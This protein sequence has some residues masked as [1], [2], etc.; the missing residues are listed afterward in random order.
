MK[1]HLIGIGGTG[2][3]AMAGL[4]SQAGHEVR[5]SDGPLY[6]PMS[7]LLEKLKIVRYEGFSETNLDWG[8]EIVVVGNICR[9]D[10][11]EAAAAAR[12]G[13]RSVSFP[14]LL[15][16]L[17]LDERRVV[18]VAGTH[19]KTTTTSMMAHLLTQAGRDPGFLVGGIPRDLDGSFAVGRPPFFVV[20]GDEYDCAYF[21]KRPKFVHYRPH[22]VILTGVEFDHADIYPTMADVERAFAL[23]IERIPPEGRL[24]CYA[25]SETAVR[26]A[27]AARCPVETYG[28]EGGPADWLGT[29]SHAGPGQQRL[30]VR[31]GPLELGAVELSLSGHHNLENALGVCA[32]AHALGLPFEAAA[33][34]LGRFRGVRRRQE[35]V[36]QSR[37]ITLVDDFAHHPTAIRETLRGLRGLHGPGRLWAVFEPRSATAKRNVFQTDLVTALA[38]ADGALI[39]PLHA[40]EKVPAGERL[41]PDRVAADLRALGREAACLAPVEVMVE[42]LAP[43]L[44]EGDTVVV[45]SSGGFDG[46]PGKLLARLNG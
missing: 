39:A 37:G 41:D 19:G 29:P 24:L 21:D 32:A 10:H 1:I 13:L 31:H 17:F 16:E 34:A 25:G 27:R 8:P 44:T 18:V 22:V 42:Y 11:V 35:V 28:L 14:E 26:L 45:M 20:E 7:T 3:G 43:R 6:P 2:M 36:G 30:L 33:N 46:L 5:G 12:R 38:E 15:G 4:L 9:R 23:L 40:P